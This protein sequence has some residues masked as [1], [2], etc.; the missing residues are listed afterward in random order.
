MKKE[1]SSVTKTIFLLVLL[2]MTISLNSNFRSFLFSNHEIK[3]TASHTGNSSLNSLHPTPRT[4][5]KTCKDALNVQLL[6]PHVRKAGGR[7]LG[8]TFD[9][10]HPLHAKYKYISSLQR[11]RKH[12]YT[13]F[14][15]H[16]NLWK[17]LAV[18]NCLDLK[19]KIPT[20]KE[21]FNAI[22]KCKGYKDAVCRQWIF[23]LRDP[24]MRSLSSFY[25][26]TGRTN[27]DDHFKCDA[28]SPIANKMRNISFSFEEFASFDIKERK[29]CFLHNQNLHLKFLTSGLIDDKSSDEEKLQ[30]AKEILQRLD[31][32]SI[33]EYAEE[34]LDLF[35]PELGLEI[36][37][38]HS[39]FNYN[40][41]EKDLT[42]Y[43]QKAK[44]VLFELN[45]LDVELYNFAKEL[46][47]ARLDKIK[48]DKQVFEC[49]KRVICWDKTSPKPGETVTITD[50]TG[51]RKKN[52]LCSRIGGCLKQSYE[53]K[54]VDLN[55]MEH[56]K[57]CIASFLIIGARMGGSTTMYKY[58]SNHKQ[59]VP[60]KLNIEREQIG[61]L[62]YF[63][64]AESI[65]RKGYNEAFIKEFIRDENIFDP[66]FHLT[67]ESSVN[68]ATN[69]EAPLL[70][71]TMCK[72]RIKVIYLV[73]D[74]VE[75]LISNMKIR[76]K[77]KEFPFTKNEISLEEAIE[78]DLI[79]FQ[80]LRLFENG[81]ISLK[82][83]YKNSIWE[84][85]YVIHLERW[86]RF[87]P[88]QDI[89]VLKSEDFFQDTKNVLQTTFDHL[90]LDS[91]SI[92][93]TT[94][95]NE[96]YN[97]APD[98]DT[99]ISSSLRRQLNELFLPYNQALER[100][101]KLNLSSWNIFKA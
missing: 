88:Q 19:R 45:Y 21:V 66:S 57:E 27:N 2:L 39:A 58:L 25:T 24:I 78:N 33:L 89:L 44:E 30:F 1:S 68:L 94:L 83:S 56:R 11:S 43:S 14:N 95:V 35:E 37:S 54:Q 15:G 50:L 99:S 92:N 29:K 96:K 55:I 49:S 72:N 41:Y 67:G 32:F 42:K 86:L 9:E 7:T 97:Q 61:E 85:L 79:Q 16:R 51:S 52:T 91:S 28:K 59:I 69:V 20:K 6:F 60:I 93:F 90:T 74:P 65:S 48:P 23:S 63:Q 31:W 36:L 62:F 8:S 76:K 81:R 17:I 26:V 4:H 18:K 80:K 22:E 71:K 47:F 12:R 46:F 5:P 77:K 82:H 98:S 40:K 70:L 13:V 64:N 75:S 53:M 34:S 87:F 3:G 101:T 10:N 73:R 100:K 38:Y 84:L